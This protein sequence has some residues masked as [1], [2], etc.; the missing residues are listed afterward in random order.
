M[1]LRQQAGHSQAK[2][3]RG[4]FVGAAAFDDSFMMDPIRASPPV[5]RYRPHLVPVPWLSGPAA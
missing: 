3:A 1:N 2:A 4:G 5:W